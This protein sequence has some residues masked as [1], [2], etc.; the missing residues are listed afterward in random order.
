V[1]W[2]INV[3]SRRTV[4][5]CNK[6]KMLT[7]L[8]QKVYGRYRDAH[9]LL[10]APAVLA[11]LLAQV[12]GVVANAVA[13]YDQ[14]LNP[15]RRPT[16]I[17]VPEGLRA[18]WAIIVKLYLGWMTISSG[19][20]FSEILLPEIVITSC[21]LPFSLSGMIQSISSRVISARNQPSNPASP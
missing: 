15:I 18:T 6:P 2:S 4:V 21:R 12:A 17:L 14:S 7:G 8:N 10:D 5:T 20:Y 13:L 3:N 16:L 9:R 1:V 19:Q 11:Q